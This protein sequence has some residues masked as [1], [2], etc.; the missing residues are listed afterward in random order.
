MCPIQTLC[1]SCRL[2]SFL[3]AQTWKLQK[4]SINE[5]SCS[6]KCIA[7][8]YPLSDAH[9]PTSVKLGFSWQPYT[10]GQY[11]TPPKQEQQNETQIYLILRLV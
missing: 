7:C 4:P 6:L 11:L 2:Q 3:V 10:T 5:D 1:P 8:L 9:K